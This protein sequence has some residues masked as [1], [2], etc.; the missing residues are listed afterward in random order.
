MNVHPTKN[1]IM[2]KASSIALATM[3]V[4]GNPG[5]VRAEEPVCQHEN[6]T[7][8]DELDATCTEAGHSA[9]DHCDD[10]GE[11]IGKTTIPA[12]GHEWE[13]TDN[14]DGTHNGR[15]VHTGCSA[16]VDNENHIFTDLS[17][18]GDRCSVCGATRT[19][20][21]QFGSEWAYD[22]TGHW[23]A[24]MASDCNEK[25]SFAEHDLDPTTGNC[26][27]CDYH[28]CVISDTYSHNETQH[29]KTCAGCDNISNLGDHI[30]ENGVCRV[31]GAEEPSAPAD[32]DPVDPDPAVPNPAT[33]EPTPAPAEEPAPEV[34]SN[35]NSAASEAISQINSAKKDDIV[36][37][38]AENVSSGVIDAL[39]DN[40]EVTAVIKVTRGDQVV[41]VSI[42]NPI[43]EEAVPYYGP[44]NLIGIH[45]R[46]VAYGIYSQMPGVDLEMLKNQLI[47]DAKNAREGI[48]P[49]IAFP[50]S[51]KYIV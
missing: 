37:I 50:A 2:A 35:E 25:G 13:Y 36:V 10:C 27:V 16:T 49:V 9:Y 34:I 28:E 23:H 41:S 38:E 26:S 12:L 48:A 14:S 40:P 4:L 30:Y 29:W 18:S 43:V 22:S 15:C 19:H 3:M 32:P 47:Q 45:N 8:V 1:R 17:A 42:N 6:V 39:S 24:C 20:E 33:P 51:D 46:G 5:I 7:H 31:C 21:D 44:E 11:D